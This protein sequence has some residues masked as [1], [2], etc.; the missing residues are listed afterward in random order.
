MISVIS[1]ILELKGLAETVYD[2]AFPFSSSQS[3]A[4]NWGHAWRESTGVGS[5]GMIKVA[6]LF[7]PTLMFG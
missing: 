1:F 4:G 2:H 7:L 5:D 6:L 3:Y